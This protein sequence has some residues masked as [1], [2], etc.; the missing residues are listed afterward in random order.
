MSL[1][2]KMNIDST[3]VK[4]K[5]SST[6]T[7]FICCI[8]PFCVVKMSFSSLVKSS[9]NWKRR[10]GIFHIKKGTP[11]NKRSQNNCKH[12]CNT[13]RIVEAY[14]I[15]VNWLQWLHWH[16]YYQFIGR[17]LELNKW[18]KFSIIDL[19]FSYQLRCHA[20]SAPQFTDNYEVQYKCILHNSWLSSVVSCASLFEINT[21]AVSWH[22]VHKDNISF[23]W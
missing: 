1:L 15:Q 13:K 2:E 16:D 22:S 23:S 17:N 7:H 6:G 10:G 18:I 20:L 11:K 5:I 4:K 14:S 19:S 8:T 12:A 21:Y 3:N 9:S